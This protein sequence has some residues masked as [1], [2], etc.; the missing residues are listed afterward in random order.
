MTKK[1]PHSKRTASKQNRKKKPQYHLTTWLFSLAAVGLIVYMLRV[2]PAA[3]A[4]LP[5]IL[6]GFAL[7]VLPHKQ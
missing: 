3:L 5:I 2:N 7:F 6:I 1:K 4:T